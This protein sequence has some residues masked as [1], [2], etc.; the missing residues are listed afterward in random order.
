[1]ILFKEKRYPYS[2]NLLKS[3]ASPF[4]FNYL[5]K[6][7]ALLQLHKARAQRTFNEKSWWFHDDCVT[8]GVTFL[9]LSKQELYG[10]WYCKKDACGGIKNLSYVYWQK[11]NKHNSN[12][13]TW[14]RWDL[15]SI[16]SHPHLIIM[17]K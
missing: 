5:T 13:M 12:F 17:G 10:T 7:S 16:R 9:Y 4:I 8:H 3:R 2:H 11:V 1:M 14:Y 15:E 6:W